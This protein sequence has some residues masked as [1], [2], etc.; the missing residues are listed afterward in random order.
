M[1]QPIIGGKVGNNTSTMALHYSNTY[2]EIT[3]GG[4]WN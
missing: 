1:M 2:T 3:L 4:G